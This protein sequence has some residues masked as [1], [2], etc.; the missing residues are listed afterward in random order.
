MD[1]ADPSIQSRH[2][3]MSFKISC[4]LQNPL[5]EVHGRSSNTHAG[6]TCL[7]T[8]SPFPGHSPGNSKLKC[9]LNFV[10]VCLT[11]GASLVTLSP[12]ELLVDGQE[13]QPGVPANSCYASVCNISA[14]SSE[15]SFPYHISDPKPIYTTTLA[16]E[17]NCRQTNIPQNIFLGHLR[18]M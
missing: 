18:P 1:H 7:L 15:S 3:S 5:T 16:I 2:P 10:S 11:L 8:G 17:C 6:V 12:S 13:I 9:G 4:S 14:T